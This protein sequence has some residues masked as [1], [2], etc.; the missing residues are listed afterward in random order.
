MRILVWNIIGGKMETYIEKL[1]ILGKKVEFNYYK[2][3]CLI[4]DRYDYSNENSTASYLG[5]EFLVYIY[6]YRNWVDSDW[7][8]VK[9]NYKN[10]TFSCNFT[11]IKDIQKVLD[12]V[13]GKCIQAESEEKDF[14]V[15]II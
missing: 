15:K 1:T 3:Y 4:C 7:F 2:E 14:S 6:W 9:V 8:G 11:K 10:V 12:Y 13:I 5:E